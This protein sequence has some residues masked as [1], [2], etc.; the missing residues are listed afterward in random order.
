[1]Y[2]FYHAYND[3]F[4][5]F[6]EPLLRRL[7][8]KDREDAEIQRIRRLIAFR[9]KAREEFLEKQRG[10]E[11]LESR[12]RNESIPLT[13]GVRTAGHPMP[14]E[15]KYKSQSTI[16]NDKYRSMDTH[17]RKDQQSERVIKIEDSYKAGV[18]KYDVK[19]EEIN[20]L[21]G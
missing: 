7:E 21:I 19:V 17:T 13:C 1:M 18:R 6:K 16:N 2:K 4:A 11:M 8:E 3:Q 14:V 10:R 12:V 9:N 20:R 5:K 15:T